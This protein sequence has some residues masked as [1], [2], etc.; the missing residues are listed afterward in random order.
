MDI[1][2]FIRLL[3][4]GRTEAALA[5]ILQEN[6]FPEVCG[7]ICPA[8]CE[9]HCIFHD[10]GSAIS[11][12]ALERYAADHGQVGAKRAVVAPSTGKRVGIIGAGAAGLAAAAILSKH[13]IAVT[14]FDASDKPGGVLRY[15]I[16]EFR[17][18]LKIIDGIID[19]LTAA[20]VV[21]KNN[22]VVGKTIGLDDIM[23]QRFD[24][25]L[26]SSG[27]Q[28]PVWPGLAGQGL[29]GVYYAREFLMRSQIHTKVSAG[30]HGA[31]MVVGEETIV[32]GPG[33]E[34]MDAARLAVRLGQKVTWIFKEFEE[35]LG[36][37][38]EDIKAT[39]AEGV[40][41]QS[42]IEAVAIEGNDKGMAS[43]VVCRSMETE[44]A[45]L[46][47][48]P[49][50]M[51]IIAT[52]GQPEESLKNLVD[53]Y[54]QG[55][56]KVFFAGECAGEGHNIAQAFASGKQAAKAVKEFLCV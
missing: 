7:R 35:Q 6:P 24:A 17:L 25:L 52:G 18:P 22:V 27:A 48:L 43:S 31:P 54:Q 16:S 44:G 12:R 34:A 2:G 45:A 10:E 55:S 32:I 15:G 1:P 11:I 28:R 53:S 42:P 36:L 29:G 49:A 41:I 30:V 33:Y 23:H 46:T 39:A 20:Q 5:R 37:H 51:V 40:V 19:Q 3:R 26:I 9:R 8:P 56:T 14:V 47:R 4:E 13:G 38:R 21:F 50:D